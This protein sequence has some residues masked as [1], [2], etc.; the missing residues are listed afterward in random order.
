MDKEKIKKIG[1]M[2]SELE[3]TDDK[4]PEIMEGFF[5]TPFDAIEI[6]IERCSDNQLQSL[7][8]LL[9]CDEDD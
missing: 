7:W 5:N 1:D 2:I 4:I 3:W 6:D 8:D 9:G